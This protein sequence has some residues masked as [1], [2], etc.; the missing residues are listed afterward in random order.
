MEENSN[1]NAKEIVCRFCLSNSARL[2]CIFDHETIDIPAIVKMITSLEVSKN[3]PFSKVACNPCIDIMKYI[4]EFREKCLSSFQKSEHKLLVSKESSVSN[5]LQLHVEFVKCETSGKD[6]GCNSYEQEDTISNR[7]DTEHEDNGDSIK[8][9]DHNNRNDCQC[10]IETVEYDFFKSSNHEKAGCTSCTKCGEHIPSGKQMLSYHMK[11]DHA[12]DGGLP[13]IRQCFYCPKAYSSYQLLKYHLNFHPQKMWQCPQ[14][15]KRIHNKAIFID[16]LRIHANERY[17]VCK[18]CG[19]RFTALKYLSSHS[20]SHKRKIVSDKI[21]DTSQEIWVQS[22]QL[23]IDTESRNLP[24]KQSQMDSLNSLH[25]NVDDAPYRTKTNIS[26]I[27]ECELCGKKL[28]TKSNY[29]N[30]R[31]MHTRKDSNGTQNVIPATC[32]EI[33]QRRVYLCN[34]CGHNCGSSSNLGVHLR[35]H[36]GQSVCE[37]SVCGKGFPRRSDLVMHMRKHTGEKPFI[38]TTCGRG[39][40]RL[41][42][43]RIH[44]RT[45][46][47]EKPYK[48]P[49]GR[50]YSQK[51]DLKT[52]QKRNS[53][54]QNFDIA[55]LQTSYP[56]TIC[57]KSP[58][59]TQADVAIESHRQQANERALNSIPGA[60]SASAT[61]S[62]MLETDSVVD[63]VFPVNWNNC[64]SVHEFQSQ[65]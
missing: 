11:S 56:R 18:E 19:K 2:Q 54:G 15:D 1:C 22:E 52:H 29:T 37:C 9:D 65:E 26:E 21:A 17:Y 41:D 35:R 48:C 45:H 33:V 10:S 53:C 6:T 42:K 13:K 34:I 43:L 64:I 12:D 27:Y 46:T 51:N 7:T 60:Y 25:Q 4:I 16:H 63:M 47:G 55:K 62:D 8:V 36:N 61:S 24:Q 50:A 23:A 57:I 40:S 38:C 32:S 14:C 31:K 39:F 58:K 3:D 44:I 49:C 20:R 28:K 30:H 59:H 5:D